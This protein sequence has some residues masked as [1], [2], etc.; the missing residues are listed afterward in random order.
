MSQQAPILA[1]EG[2]E[3]TC[4]VALRVNET[5]FEINHNQ[6]RSH[7]DLLLESVHQLLTEHNI[8]GPSLGRIV[9]ARGP[10]AFTGLRICIAIAQGLGFSWNKVLT[11][12][13]TL[14]ALAFAAYQTKSVKRVY[15]ALD[16]RMDEIYIAGFEFSEHAASQNILSEQVI[17]PEHLLSLNPKLITDTPYLG[18]GSG[19]KYQ[20]TL[21]QQLGSATQILKDQ[22]LKASQLITFAITKQAELSTCNA[23]ALEPTYLRNEVAKKQPKQVR[24]E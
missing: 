23:T 22:P 10:G 12:I 15:A 9:V 13:S 20:T 3:S 16:A 1:L 19:W 6:A 14:K 8:K 21:E 11:P 5:T 2:S 24:N 4:S 17:A 7:A 18:I